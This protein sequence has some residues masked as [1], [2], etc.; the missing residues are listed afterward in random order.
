MASNHVHSILRPVV[1]G[2][3][4]S[5][6]A[7]RYLCLV[8]AHERVGKTGN[9]RVMGDWHPAGWMWGMNWVVVWIGEG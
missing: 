5:T 2:T 7:G 4:V 8:W 9:D 3:R 1:V 6:L